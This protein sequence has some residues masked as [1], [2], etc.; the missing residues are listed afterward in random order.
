MSRQNKSLQL[1]V[2]FRCERRRHVSFHVT[3]N[4]QSNKTQRNKKIT[5]RKHDED[6]F[7]FLSL[8]IFAS[9]TWR[10]ARQTRLVRRIDISFVIFHD[11]NTNKEATNRAKKKGQSRKNE[12]PKIGGEICALRTKAVRVYTIF[13]S[14]NDKKRNE[15]N[16][17]LKERAEHAVTDARLTQFWAIIKKRNAE[18]LFVHRNFIDF[19]ALTGRPSEEKKKIMKRKEHSCSFG[20]QIITIDF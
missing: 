14:R 10:C 15:I 18:N 6:D 2:S 3:W 20:H 8:F 7:F 13:A 16:Q 11:Q 1:W 12:C 17:S 5:N 19:V 9:S 4:L